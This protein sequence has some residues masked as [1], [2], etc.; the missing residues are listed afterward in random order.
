[1][2]TRETLVII[3][4]SFSRFL[5]QV[6]PWPQL[7]KT[8]M[9]W[10]KWIKHL[11]VNLPC[12]SWQQ[13]TGFISLVSVV[14]VNFLVIFWSV[15]HQIFQNCAFSPFCPHQEDVSCH[16]GKDCRSGPS[17]AVL[18]RHGHCACGQQEIQVPSSLTNIWMEAN[19]CNT[20]DF[21]CSQCHPEQ[22]LLSE[23][24]TVL[25]WH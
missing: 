21:S 19:D 25:T 12:N 18:H 2:T 13:L 6:P 11:W 17:S 8:I 15:H 10:N 9:K 22:R 5:P 4:Q 7:Q 23:Q 3:S 1:M 24:K 14:M 16:A 20:S